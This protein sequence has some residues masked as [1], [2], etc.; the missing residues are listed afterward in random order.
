[1]RD[2]GSFSNPVVH[3]WHDAQFGCHNPKYRMTKKRKRWYSEGERPV[4][5]APPLVTLN[6]V[7]SNSGDTIVIYC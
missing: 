6:S 7:N 1:M 2:D 3:M 5:D 4:S